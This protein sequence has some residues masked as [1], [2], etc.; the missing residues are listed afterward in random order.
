VGHGAILH[1]HDDERHCLA[2]GRHRFVRLQVRQEPVYGR[3]RAG[4]AGLRAEQGTEHG[5]SHEKRVERSRRRGADRHGV[6]VGHPQG[7]TKA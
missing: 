3:T 5:R 1:H 7:R 6:A 2:P 4:R